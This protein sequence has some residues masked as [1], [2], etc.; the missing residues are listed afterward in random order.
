MTFI[1]G[2]TR[3]DGGELW[4]ASGI[5]AWAVPLERRLRRRFSA[6]FVEGD[7]GFRLRGRL[8][9]VLAKGIWWMRCSR[10]MRTQPSK[11]WRT[12]SEDLGSA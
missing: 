3:D 10:S 8:T 5:R 12:Q 4:D 6:S 9:L 7:D 11:E 1:L 2:S